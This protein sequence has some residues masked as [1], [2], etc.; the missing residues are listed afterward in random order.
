MTTSHLGK[1]AKVALG[2]NTV[3]GIGNWGIDG[4]SKAEIDDTEFGDQA[5]K[6]A[7]GIENGGT[8]SFAGNAKLGDTTGQLALMEAYDLDTELTDL[9]LYIDETSYFEPCQTAGY[10]HPGKTTGAN[11]QVS[12]VIITGYP[13]S[14]DKGG[15]VAISFS[16]RINGKM[17]LV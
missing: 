2:A 5:T 3:L 17:V 9:R 16:G 10:L 4:T 14:T 13:I 12:S 15:L 8:I 1:D 11:T 6:Y 7:L